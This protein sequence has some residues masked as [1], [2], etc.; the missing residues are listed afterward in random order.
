MS[1]IKVR[2]RH[3]IRKKILLIDWVDSSSANGWNHIEAINPSLKICTSIGFLINETKDALILA[4]HLSF[5]P[6]LCSG[7]I[8][9]PKVAIIRRRAIGGEK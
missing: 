5:D 8:S 1:E 9:I 7:D 4:A 6:D 2:Y 3:L